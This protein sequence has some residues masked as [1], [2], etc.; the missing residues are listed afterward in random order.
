MELMIFERLFLY[1]FILD[2][3]GD[4]DLAYNE[5]HNSISRV[6]SVMMS[7]VIYAILGMLAFGCIMLILWFVIA[8]VLLWMHFG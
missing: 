1:G 8:Y 7:K 4:V 3:S 6:D 5:C 2:S